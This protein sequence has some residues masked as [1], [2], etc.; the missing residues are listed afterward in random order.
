MF[1]NL[2]RVMS[3]ILK[4]MDIHR[5][6]VLRCVERSRS[7]TPCCW[8]VADHTFASSK[9]ASCFIWSWRRTME[10]FEILSKP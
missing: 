8:N 2:L 5:H 10:H 7:C 1:I 3:F 6:S 9:L 4:F